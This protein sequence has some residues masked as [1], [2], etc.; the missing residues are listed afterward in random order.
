MIDSFIEQQNQG[1]NYKFDTYNDFL[2]FIKNNDYKDAIISVENLRDVLEKENRFLSKDE[3]IG[4]V[5]SK[6]LHMGSFFDFD[7]KR[8]LLSRTKYWDYVKECLFG[9]FKYGTCGLMNINDLKDE[10]IKQIA[11]VIC[12]DLTSYDKKS[13][14][15]R[16]NAGKSQNDVFFP[17]NKEQLANDLIRYKQCFNKQN[18]NNSKK[19]LIAGI[20]LLTL[21]II[22]C[23]AT[24]VLGLTGKLT[25]ILLLFFM[26]TLAGGFGCLLWSKISDCVR[27]CCLNSLNKFDNNNLPKIKGSNR[28]NN[29]ERL[30]TVLENNLYETNKE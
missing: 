15:L 6:K 29:Q 30:K 9:D 12:S 2:G 8:L 17:G 23:G 5:S 16:V 1:S 7:E 19:R 25:F 11:E 10:D 4:F 13:F 18:T 21:G 22:G 14:F 24:C 3:F 27:P 26:I 28:E 20:I